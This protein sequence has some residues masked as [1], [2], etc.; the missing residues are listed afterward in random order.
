[1]IHVAHIIPTLSFGGAEHLVIDLVNFSNHKK[2]KFSI[3]TLFDNMPLREKIERKDV[4]VFLV[5]KKG[6][7]SFHLRNDLRE[8][9]RELKPDIVHTHLFGA[10]LWRA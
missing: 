5:P 7:L 4:G 9:L 8:K 10:D 6:K 2:F 1:M 3:I